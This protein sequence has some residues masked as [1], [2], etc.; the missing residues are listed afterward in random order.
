M[1]NT[2]VIIVFLFLI[3]GSVVS[4]A[5]EVKRTRRTKYSSKDSVYKLLPCDSTSCLVFKSVFFFPIFPWFQCSMDRE[6]T[7]TQYRMFRRVSGVLDFMLAKG[8]NSYSGSA[9][10]L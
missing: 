8:N 5:R 6:P 10:W 1:T 4:D 9:S 2:K 3:F 7:R